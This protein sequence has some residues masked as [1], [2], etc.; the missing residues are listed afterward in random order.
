[1]VVVKGKKRKNMK[2]NFILHSKFPSNDL[3]KCIL[4]EYSRLPRAD[5]NLRPRERSL[6]S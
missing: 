4:I 3:K 5:M 2:N 6:E 1:M